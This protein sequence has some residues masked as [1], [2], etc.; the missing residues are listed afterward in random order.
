MTVTNTIR[1]D[2][3]FNHITTKW[4]ESELS[5][6]EIEQ[7]LKA[8]ETQGF[9]SYAYGCWITAYGRFIINKLIRALDRYVVYR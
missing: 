3:T 9:L 8:D 5:N 6:F 2:V 1:D 7:K 4:E